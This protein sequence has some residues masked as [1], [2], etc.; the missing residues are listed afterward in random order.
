MRYIN[1]ILIMLFLHACNSEKKIRHQIESIR[2][3]DA[4]E[5]Y[6][7][8]IACMEYISQY[9]D[10]LAYSKGLIRKLLEAGFSA[11][12]IS[13]AEILLGKF[14]D[15]P[16]LYNLR[17]LGYL[18]MHQYVLAI[19]DYNNAIRIQPENKQFLIELQSVR[20]EEKVWNE[21]QVMNGSLA[22]SADSF[23]VL[24]SRAEKL[25]SIREYDAVLYD[26][27]SISKLGSEQDS[28][29]YV[30]QV[31]TLNQEKGRK[32]V[33]VLSELIQYYGKVRNLDPKA[34]KAK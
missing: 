27:G 28:L 22:N 1:L 23:D 11:E 12:V 5:K 34:R 3:Q 24:L 21:I 18:N 29:Y 17:G 19:A 32:S 30:S 14:P 16:E 7:L 25:Y 31:S 9:G 26:L 4:T 2:I 20:E 8:G 6:D 33:E 10:D 15:D 13:A